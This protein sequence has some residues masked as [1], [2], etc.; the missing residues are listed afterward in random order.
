MVHVFHSGK[1]GLLWGGVGFC[2][3]CSFVVDGFFVVVVVFGGSSGGASGL[4]VCL[5]VCLDRILPY[6][7]G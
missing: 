6:S 4:F 5:F 2:F 1:H 3:L 7:P